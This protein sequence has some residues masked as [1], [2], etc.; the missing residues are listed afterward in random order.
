MAVKAGFADKDNPEIMDIMTQGVDL[1][2][3]PATK[4]FKE[5]IDFNQSMKNLARKADSK[6]RQEFLEFIKK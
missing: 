6:A 3:D 5:S 2:Y 1:K 4:T